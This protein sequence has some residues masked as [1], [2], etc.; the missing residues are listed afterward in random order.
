MIWDNIYKVEI[1]SNKT[2]Y[3]ISD[4]K[5]SWNDVEVVPE[6]SSIQK[7]WYSKEKWTV[8]KAQIINWIIELLKTQKYEYWNMEDTFLK[9]S[10]V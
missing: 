9:I 10:K 2:Q 4:I 6:L 5:I 8:S 7:L 1:F 3:K